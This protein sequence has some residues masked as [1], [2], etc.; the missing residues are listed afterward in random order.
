MVN[1]IKNKK[2][3]LNYE[4][5]N[6]LW[7]VMF[8]L[9]WIVGT[10]LFFVYPVIESFVLVFCDVKFEPSGMVRKFTGLQNIKNVFFRDVYP[11]QCIVNALKDIG[12]NLVIVMAISIL[13][14]LLLNQKFKGRGF[15][16]TA[17]ALP[18]IIG[19]G[20]LIKIF[21]GDLFVQSSDISGAAS[22]VFQGDAISQILLQA[23]L[24]LN[25]I[26]S[27]VGVVNGVVD[28]IWKCGVEIL[29]FL[30]GLQAI[31]S[32]LYEVCEIDGAS[33]WQKFWLITFPLM[34]PFILLNAIYIIIDS[35]TYYDNNV[36]LEVGW[37][38]DALMYGYANTLSF[39]YCIIV[40]IIVAIVG[41]LISRRVTYLD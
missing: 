6:T 19:T 28:L 14:A 39:T 40:G 12:L 9:P 34:T 25:I 23:G 11:L 18:V 38:F 22:T 16:R 27:I 29:L 3:S 35:A 26:E 21:K 5:R 13:I 2:L 41:G 15:A 17:F 36:M 24:P 1:K 37:K 10:L 30:S 33:A 4:S 8:L 7:G 32:Y 31:P 20:I